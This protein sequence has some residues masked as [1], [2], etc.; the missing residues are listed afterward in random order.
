MFTQVRL[1]AEQN[2]KAR[3]ALREDRQERE[4]FLFVERGEKFSVSRES[5][6]RLVDFEL[7]G[8]QIAISGS[9]LS[10][11]F[12]ATVTLQDVFGHCRLK[13][14]GVEYDRWQV[15]RMAL[16]ELFFALAPR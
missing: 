2:V 14:D 9:G 6:R 3:N 11:P 13:V 15:L 10:T 16:E 12:T 4:K 1:D 5:V 8:D 7:A